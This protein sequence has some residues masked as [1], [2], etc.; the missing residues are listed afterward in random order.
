MV[1]HVGTPKSGTTYLQDLLWAS[2]DALAEAGIACPGDSP[3]AHFQAALDLQQIDFH[4]WSDPAVPGAW[5]RLVDAAREHEGTTVISHELLGDLSAEQV[6]RVMADLD[7][8]EV[9]VVLTARD[10]ARQLPAVWQ[11]DVKNRHH[12]PLAEFLDVVRPGSDRADV[13][14]PGPGRPEGH[15]A[16]FWL[17]QDLPAVLRRWGAGLPAD[18]V[19]L[20]TLPPPGTAGPDVLWERFAGVLGVDPAAATL[21]PRARNTGLGRTE[22]EL[23][24]RLNERLDYS[25]DW[26][27][28]GTAVTR[29]LGEVLAQRPGLVPLALPAHVRPW[30]S[31]HADAMAAELA[32]LPLTVVG[33]L[34]D[35]QV[36]AFAV[37]GPAAGLPAVE[38]G[39]LLE[40]ALDTLTAVLAPGWVPPPR[41][42][43]AEPEPV[44]AAEPAPVPAARRRGWR[45]WRRV[46][47]DRAGTAVAGADPSP[48]GAGEPAPR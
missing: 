6:A 38:Q 26:P 2:R 46:L 33:D 36:S 40:A 34:A 14:R 30:V 7:F 21:P 13:L 10:L 29:S 4:G 39:D 16:T 48:L 8:A 45:P 31:A 28:Y 42:A 18:R 47:R 32:G 23:L 24:R 43:V 3:A 17:R 22:A 27:R 20:V 5:T 37:P 41:P 44:P 11:E 25:L 1:L 19:H 9:H 12:L 15:G 35:L